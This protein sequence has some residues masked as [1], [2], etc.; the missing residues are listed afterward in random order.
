LKALDISSTSTGNVVLSEA[1]KKSAENVSAGEALSK[2]LADSGIFPPQ[3]M[4]MITVAEESNTLE[5]VLIGAAD[6]IERQV[7]RRL[8]MIVRL[9][10]PMM[11]L[12]MAG[13]VLLILLAL[14]MPMFQ[15][16]EGF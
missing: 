9:M 8:D 1:I 7:T 2:P 10:E 16:G 12:G 13:V 14:L 4:A 15:L 11:L 3:V 6:S 5:N